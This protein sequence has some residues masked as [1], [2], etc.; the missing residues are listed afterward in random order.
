MHH[1]TQTRFKVIQKSTLYL[2]PTQADELKRE[3]D[4]CFAFGQQESAN[5]IQL[6]EQ[7][8]S[9]RRTV[10]SLKEMVSELRQHYRHNGLDGSLLE[11][12]DDGSSHSFAHNLCKS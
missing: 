8:E 2:P 11:C 6:A 3:R 10:D 5:A 1:N 4:K 9:E 12:D 7:L